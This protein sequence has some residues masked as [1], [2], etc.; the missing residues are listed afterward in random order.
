MIPENIK[1]AANKRRT[2]LYETTL[3]YL[4]ENE[5]VNQEQLVEHLNE[6]HPRK[7]WNAKSVGHYLIPL[8]SSGLIMRKRKRVLGIMGT[9]Y[10]LLLFN[11]K[12]TVEGT[13]DLES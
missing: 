2:Q 7:E 10:S 4:Q 3:E 11:T 6:K 5:T 9:Y 13:H 12:G 1:K 8:V